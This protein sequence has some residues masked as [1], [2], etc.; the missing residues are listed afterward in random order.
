[1]TFALLFCM[2]AGNLLWNLLYIGA[3]TRLTLEQRS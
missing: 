1:M 3:A 2:I